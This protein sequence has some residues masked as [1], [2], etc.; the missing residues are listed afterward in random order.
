M[1][2]KSSFGH[3]KD[4]TDIQRMAKTLTGQY[5]KATWNSLRFSSYELF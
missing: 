4:R 2:Q 5:R 1:V 3:S